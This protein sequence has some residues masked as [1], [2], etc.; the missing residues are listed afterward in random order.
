MK[1]RIK[2][3]G[4]LHSFFAWPLV[5][6]LILLVATTIIFC[7]NRSAGNV[8]LLFWLLY[9]V[10]TIVLY[11]LAKPS[12][13][14]ELVNFGLEYGQIQ[15]N[16]MNELALPY[17]LLDHTGKI[18]WMNEAL[19]DLIGE[20]NVM[21][22]ISVVFEEV[23][24]KKLSFEEKDMQVDIVYDEHD[25]RALFRCISVDNFAH[26]NSIID[27]AKDESM[28]IAMYLFDETQIKKFQKETENEKMVCGV[29]FIDNYEDVL[30]ST[31]EV[32]RSLLAALIDRKINKYMQSYDAI[33]TKVEKDRY[34]FII[35]KKY[36]PAIQSSRFSLL[37]EV[38]EINIGNELPVTLCVGV[39]I[40]ASSLTE[41]YDW[42]RS[43]IDLALGRG[44]DQAVFKDGDKISYYGGKTKQIEKTTRVRA[45]VKAHALKQLIEGKEQVVIM[46]HK[47]ADTDSFGAAIGVYR[48]AK[49]LNK[50]AYI[51]IDEISTS[52]KPMIAQF[53]GNPE[54]EPDMFLKSYEA[55]GIVDENTVLVVV[56]VNKKAY[57]QAPALLDKT[58]TIV[59]LDHHRQSSESVVNPLLSYIE[60]YA[61]STCEMVAEILQYIAEGVKLRPCEADV[62]YA[63]LLIDTNN[64]VNKTGTR[65]FEAAAFLKKSGADISKIRMTFRD[66]ADVFRI[67][68]IAEAGAVIDNDM[69]FAVCPTEGVQSPSIVGAQIANELLN[70]NGINASFVFTDINGIIYISARSVETLNVQLIMERLG[71][72]GHS[73]IAGA[74]LED[75]SV[76]EAIDRVKQEIKVMREEG[77]L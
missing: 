46:G 17:G 67:K 11:Q 61:S 56:D 1:T 9:V 58:K 29:I 44:G 27:V 52:V 2:L 13:M 53:I 55:E 66:E 54:Y 72:G 45:R 24:L 51:V 26:K 7:M 40:N 65:T 60:P 20:K 22:N 62:M 49:V 3:K 43:G 28:L 21:R 48:A 73:T 42:A 77:A 71:G 76:N 63:G 6:S 31:E 69:A 25:F 75:I 4:Q 18:L 41:A 8:M 14:T 15:K 23:S 64:F 16:M 32:R 34:T 36:L 59:V 47:M 12:V 50:R 33:L 30:K 70:I 57:S 37:D 74:Q 35:K 39:G 19:K 5:Y 68:A 10:I 38:R